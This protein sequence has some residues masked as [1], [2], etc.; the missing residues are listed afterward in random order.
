METVISLF[1]WDL[2]RYIGQPFSHE[3]RFYVEMDRKLFED[4]DFDP[5]WVLVYIFFRRFLSHRLHER[6]QYFE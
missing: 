5:H 4:T 3:Y 2:L 1:R 6:R